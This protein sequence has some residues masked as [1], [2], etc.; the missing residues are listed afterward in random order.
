MENSS[1]DEKSLLSQLNDERASQMLPVMV[2]IGLLMVLGITGNVMVCYF[3]G[4]KTKHTSNTMFIIGLAIFDLVTCTMTIPIDIYDL[5][6]FHMFYN[7]GACKA[8]RFIG[9]VASGGS[10]IILFAIAI[11]RYRRICRPFITQFDL[12]DAAKAL[13]IA[14]VVSIIFSWPAAILY[15]PERVLVQNDFNVTLYGSDCT[16]TRT[17]KLRLFLWVFNGIYLLGFIFSVILLGVLYYRI[18]KVLYKHNQSKKKYTKSSHTCKSATGNAPKQD[19]D[20]IYAINCQ[21]ENETEIIE[22]QELNTNIT[23]PSEVNSIKPNG[24][25]PSVTRQEEFRQKTADEKSAQ[26]DR[27]TMKYTIVMLSITAVFIISYLPYMILSIWRAFAGSHEANSLSDVGLVFFQIG[28]RSYMLN[29]V[30]NPFLYGFFNSRFR[31][32]FYGIFCTCFMPSYRG[33]KSSS[34]SARQ[35]KN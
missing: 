15:L 31:E 34:S 19:V 12:K 23:T 14:F 3:Y 35:N 22:I 27:K 17:G 16:T 13:V 29:S 11:D 7:A 30:I 4:Y 6:Y 32:F 2:Y 9:H 28:L 8:M 33:N 5:R 20:T 1:I 18:G 26:I 24:E 25:I 21:T 10:I